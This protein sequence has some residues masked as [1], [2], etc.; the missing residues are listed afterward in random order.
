MQQAEHGQETS[1]KTGLPRAAGHV[2]VWP[3]HPGGEVVHLGR[4]NEK[5]CARGD[6]ST[7]C[8][9]QAAATRQ[10]ESSRKLT[11]SGEQLR[12]RTRDPPGSLLIVMQLLH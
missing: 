6:G 5:M 10:T 9:R 3:A 7:R 8:Q 1:N 12:F 4:G 11:G 2:A